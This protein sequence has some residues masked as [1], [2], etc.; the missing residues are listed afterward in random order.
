MTEDPLFGPLVVFGLGGIFVELM[1]DVAFRINPLTDTEAREMIAEVK[2]AQLLSGYRGEPAG[3]VDALVELLLR[4]S[5]L[6]DD[7]PEIAEMDLNPVKALEPGQGVRVVDARI[8]VRRVEG[9]VLP[10]R[11]DVPGRLA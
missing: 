8:R 2:A 10:S 11:K 1:K 5:A 6:I 4:V 3:D 9:A 7:T